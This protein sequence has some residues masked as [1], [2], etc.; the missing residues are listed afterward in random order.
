MEYIKEGNTLP[1]PFNILLLPID[2]IRSIKNLVN[3]IMKKPKQTPQIEAPMPV[4]R[5]QQNG[6]AINGDIKV[7]LTFSNS[8]N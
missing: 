3:Y 5:K 8:I 1:V 2:I 7:K 6:E 4:K